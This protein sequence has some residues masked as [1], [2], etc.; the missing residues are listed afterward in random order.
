[1]AAMRY[2]LQSWLHL[3]AFALGVLAVVTVALGLSSPVVDL[4]ALR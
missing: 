1:M 4:V 3:A 2:E